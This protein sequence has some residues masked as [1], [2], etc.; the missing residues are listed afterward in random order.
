MFRQSREERQLR[1]M[2][3]AEYRAYERKRYIDW[4]F[5]VLEPTI[6]DYLDR[7]TLPEPPK[8]LGISVNFVNT[9]K[10]APKK[11]PASHAAHR[12]NKA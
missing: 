9:T 2:L 4:V 3:I 6:N 5:D 11:K 10:P 1:A 12:R 7:A 8:D